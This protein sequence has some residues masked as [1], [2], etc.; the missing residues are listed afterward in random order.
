M[1]ERSLCDVPAIKECANCGR[2]DKL[3]RCSRCKAEWFCSLKCHRS[4]WPFHKEH[5]KINEF[6]DSLEDEEPEF[7]RWM[8]QHRK[9]AVLGDEEVA[10]LEGSAQPRQEVL[11]S[12]YGVRHL[13]RQ[14]NAAKTSAGQPPGV[15]SRQP[16]VLVTDQAL[17]WLSIDIPD[18]LG[19]SCKRYKWCQSQSHVHVYVL[20]APGVT[21]R[22]VKV[23]LEPKALSI[24]VTREVI[25][26]GE[27][28]QKVKQEDSTWTIEDGILHVSLLKSNRRGHYQD[29]CTNADTYW[30]RVFKDCPPC[31][32]LPGDHPP[33]SYYC[34]EYEETDLQLDQ[35][36]RR[37]R[38][39]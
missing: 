11:A 31:E 37:T 9:L 8:R 29:G 39:E 27:L 7:A 6:A 26:D 2:T 32:V 3:L 10:L 14:G 5:C 25:I 35:P 22:Q 34:C 33:V 15:V 13:H 17:E 24:S 38:Q 23:T 30:S 28:H 1:V 18:G 19:L 12:L 4:Y 36:R 16:A 21:S 20:L